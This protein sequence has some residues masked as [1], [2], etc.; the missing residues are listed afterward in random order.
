MSHRAILTA[1]TITMVAGR[2]GPL[3]PHKRSCVLCRCIGL[4][5]DNPPSKQICYSWGAI[6]FM[7][8]KMLL[9]YGN[10]ASPQHWS[11][12]RATG[13]ITP[14]KSIFTCS[15]GCPCSDQHAGARSK[16]SSGGPLGAHF[17]WR[18][19]WLGKLWLWKGR[20]APLNMHSGPTRAYRGLPESS[21]STQA[22]LWHFTKA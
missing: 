7:A 2:E 19:P 1:T 3:Q 6:G 9:C 14:T 16:V 20:G 8:L 5:G 10:D 18:R 22:H 4:I 12:L 15:G 11:I 21:N 17:C 13:P